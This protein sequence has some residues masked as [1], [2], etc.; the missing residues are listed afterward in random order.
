M[1]F[2]KIVGS[3][4]HLFE[5]LFICFLIKKNQGKKIFPEKKMQALPDD[6]DTTLGAKPVTDKVTEEDVVQMTSNV[7]LEFNDFS[8]TF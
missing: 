6:F 8:I 3:C 2:K 4:L 7:T 1:C 5:L